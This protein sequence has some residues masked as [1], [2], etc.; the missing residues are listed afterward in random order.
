[1]AYL[2]FAYWARNNLWY[3]LSSG[4]KREEGE[5]IPKGTKNELG[6]L[7]HRPLT[8]TYAL[9]CGSGRGR[10]GGGGKKEKK[11]EEGRREREKE[12]NAR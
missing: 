7:R 12:G 6:N 5:N 10:G 11:R 8:Q 9:C 4:E 3:L 1:M 2:Q